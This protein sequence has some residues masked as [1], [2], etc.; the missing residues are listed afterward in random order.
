MY[1][2]FDCFPLEEFKNAG[3]VSN[4]NNHDL[5]QSADAELFELDQQVLQQQPTQQCASKV[6][7]VHK[8]DNHDEVYHHVHTVNCPVYVPYNNEKQEILLPSTT[9]ISH[10]KNT[11]AL[12]ADENIDEWNADP[13]FDNTNTD[14]E[15]YSYAEY[16]GPKQLMV[17]AIYIGN[18]SHIYLC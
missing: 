8:H 9:E 12:Y 18:Y 17:Q 1:E 14:T 2:E 16:D 3:Q 7:H 15:T 11:K 10:K 13:Y 5:K 6:S 4:I